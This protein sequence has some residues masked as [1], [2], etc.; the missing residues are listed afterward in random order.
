MKG[1]QLLSKM[2]KLML[3]T[4]VIGL[5]T[6][7]SV[8]AQEYLT[9]DHDTGV[10]TFPD[11]Q[12]YTPNAGFPGD[13]ITVTGTNLLTKI[14]TI[15]IGA[16]EAE[17][18]TE[19][20][21]T[22]LY[23]V[24][25]EPDM[26]AEKDTISFTTDDGSIFGSHQ[27]FL[28]PKQYSDAEQLVM[29]EPFEDA[30]YGGGTLWWGVDANKDYQ[31]HKE[32]DYSGSASRIWFGVKEAKYE[33]ASQ[34][35]VYGMKK[36]K[37]IIISKIN[38]LGL[39]NIRLSFSMGYWGWLVLEG[40][41]KMY[42][43]VDGGEYIEFGGSSMPYGIGGDM[44]LV[45]VGFKL[46]AAENLSIKWEVVQ[47]VEQFIMIDDVRITGYP[48]G[49]AQITGIEPMKQKVGK[50]VQVLGSSL[51]NVSKVWLGEIEVTEFTTSQDGKSLS[52]VVP[53]GADTV[54]KAQVLIERT[55]GGN[56]TSVEDLEALSALP[57]INAF[58]PERGPIGG[59][60]YLHG[61]NLYNIESLKFGDVEATEFMSLND[62]VAEVYVPEGATTDFVAVKTFNHEM[63]S[64]SLEEFIVDLAF[65]IITITASADEAFEGDDAIEIKLTTSAAALSE[66]KV[67]L[68][69]SGE[70]ISDDDYELDKT[71]LTIAGGASESDLAMLKI[72][73]DGD[74]FEEEE[75]L[76]L[77]MASTIG[78]GAVI[79]EARSVSIL[80]KLPDG[81]T[82]IDLERALDKLKVHAE[83]NQLS[84]FMENKLNLKE[85]QISIYNAEGRINMISLVNVVNGRATINAQHLQRGMYIIRLNTGSEILT[86]RFIHQ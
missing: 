64:T 8:N 12:D 46:P 6:T 18:I 86:G 20:T 7:F 24:V 17:I 37:N 70:G 41:L 72:L 55:E 52:L 16:A 21:D 45:R 39:E 30:P 58:S 29:Y 79:G 9:K 47:E 57:A 23:F 75:T 13:T 43:S 28:Y 62:T 4:L 85:A 78:E 15:K 5:A 25:P 59:L 67:M 50:E 82:S 83:N 2:S 76:V 35:A 80:I 19:S 27:P 71:E 34:R 48:E 61:D 66:T 51:T 38:T 54:G 22:E 3:T 14:K 33:G 69:V 42:Y 56:V 84:L 11:L 32:I 1:L 77:T 10:T 63:D 65:P 60:I 26:D 73:E 74:D 49:A 44:N 81:P 36:D 31:E 53:F 68:A 40:Q